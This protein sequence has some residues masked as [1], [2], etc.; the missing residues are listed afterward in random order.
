[1]LGDLWLSYSSLKVLIRMPDLFRFIKV[2]HERSHFIFWT[3]CKAVLLV[4]ISIALRFLP[5]HYFESWILPLEMC[6]MILRFRAFHHDFCWVLL[7]YC[8]VHLY[9]IRLIDCNCP[10]DFL[11]SSFKWM[12]RHSW[13]VSICIWSASVNLH[14]LPSQ[15]VSFSLL[16]SVWNLSLVCKSSS[17]LVIDHLVGSNMEWWIIIVVDCHLRVRFM[18]FQ[19]R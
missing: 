5:A 2:Y 16:I 6:H 15:I 11:W 7:C 19:V 18:D 3:T 8:Q 1:M 14:S 9:L 10:G 17:C 4:D 12:M 13:C